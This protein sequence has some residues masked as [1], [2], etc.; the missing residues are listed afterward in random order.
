[1]HT[2]TFTL[3]QH[4]PLIHFQHTQDG[5]TLRATEVKPKLDRFICK[6]VFKDDFELIKTYLVGY[7]L[8]NERDLKE[9]FGKGFR[10]LDYKLQ[11]ITPETWEFEIDRYKI[12]WNRDNKQYE[13][14]KDEDGVKKF[15][16]FP[17]FFGNM[18]DE[19]MEE[20]KVFLFFKGDIKI[21]I[22]CFENSLLE[23]IQIHFQHFIGKETFATRSS[24]GFGSF[25]FVITETQQVTYI[26]SLYYFTVNVSSINANLDRLKKE[27]KF[28][29]HN[30]SDDTI[31]KIEKQRE[32]FRQIE[33]FYR[34][35][36]SGFNMP[37]KFYI[38]SPLWAFMANK[39]IQ[40]EKKTIKH[41]YFSHILNAQRRKYGNPD[42]L[43]HY[44]T[45]FKRDTK[46][47]NND[48][49]VHEEYYYLVRDMLGLAVE[50]EWKTY[51]SKITKEHG[52]IKRFKSPIT[53]KPFNLGNDKFRVDLFLNFTPDEYRNELFTIKSNNASDLS[54][55]TPDKTVFTLTKYFNF[56]LNPNFSIDDLIT[57][58]T[59]GYGDY[60][61]NDV[62]IIKRLFDDLKANYHKATKK[63]A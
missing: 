31:L 59:D 11:I 12:K 26:P 57:C 50:S 32:L 8:K 37:N 51:Y 3:K 40:W 56:I 5:A 1:M 17:C 43:T 61:N 2:L 44:K 41:K 19:N 54:L 53:F 55:I 16:Q 18:G 38:K 30:V 22:T 49:V 25:A 52:E 39:D 4:T 35:L 23:V 27:Y 34:V 21:N 20:P 42:V 63:N 29:K 46:I 7:S 28:R 6:T 33:L 36:R 13:F 10:A 45:I 14:D 62:Q 48:E 15:E 24:K 58:E 60:K 47:E 9:K